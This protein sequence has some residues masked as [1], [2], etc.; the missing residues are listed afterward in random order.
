V[1]DD[2]ASS[3]EA[4][5]TNAREAV[6]G[7]VIVPVHEGLDAESLALNAV[8]SDVER[9]PRFDPDAVGTLKV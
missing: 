3:E 7:V 5:V 4:P 8:Q 9:R 2:T 6:S 1:V